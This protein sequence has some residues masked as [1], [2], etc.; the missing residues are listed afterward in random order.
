MESI[1]MN[2]ECPS[3]PEF[4]A[5][6]IVGA[7]LV[8]LRHAERMLGDLERQTADPARAA[9][10]QAIRAATEALRQVKGRRPE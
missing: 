10:L 8:D 7:A 9:N 1:P 5:Y 3:I 6:N 2:A 4:V